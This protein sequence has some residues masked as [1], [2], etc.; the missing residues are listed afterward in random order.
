MQDR[1]W[2]L[3]SGF[4]L[5]ATGLSVRLAEAQQ[6]GAMPTWAAGR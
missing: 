3:G 4:A 6:A 5:A 2:M 1:R